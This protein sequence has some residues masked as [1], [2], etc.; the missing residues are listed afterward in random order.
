MSEHTSEPW[1]A[2]D[3]GYIYAKVGNDPNWCI[4]KTY[5]A[6]DPSALDAL[7]GSAIEA[8]AARIVAC[9]NACAGIPTSALKE[10]A[11]KELVEVAVLVHE[12]PGELH[13]WEDFS[14]ILANFTKDT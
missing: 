9:V 3:N 11:V 7:T 8:N 10:R 13:L 2:R 1:Q 14:E 6:P 4:G 12:N 5:N